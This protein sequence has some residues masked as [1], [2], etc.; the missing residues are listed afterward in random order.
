MADKK[1]TEL[2]E[3]TSATADDLVYLVDDPAGTP[4]SK[5]ITVANFIQ[6]GWI[7]ADTMTYASADDP[8]YTMTCSGDKTTT[9]YAGQKIKLTQ[10]TGGTKYF[11]VTKVEYS[12]PNTTITMYGGTDYNLENEAITNPYYSIVKA[13]FGFPLDPTKWTVSLVDSSERTQTSPVDTT[14][15]NLGSLSLD[16]PIG[17]WN[18]DYSIPL[19]GYSNPGVSINVR[20]S[21]STSSNSVSDSHF[22]AMNY[23]YRNTSANTGYINSLYRAKCIVLTSKATYYLIAMSEEGSIGGISFFGSIAPTIVRAVCAYL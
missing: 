7:S 22:I 10:S 9:Y 12:N 18:V 2:D 21:L 16:I 5:K 13:P 20:C 3:I 11:I 4:L 19:Y 15:Y 1:L 6:G 17:I 14:W 23:C 8:T